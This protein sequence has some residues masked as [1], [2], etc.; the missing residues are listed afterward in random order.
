MG[1]KICFVGFAS[2][3]REWANNLPDDDWEI[4]GTNEC[5]LFLRKQPS[6]WYQIHPRG[7]EPDRSK[8]R[9]YIPNGFGRPYYHQHWLSGQSDFPIY[10]QEKDPLIPRSVRYPYEKVAALS[11]PMFLTST[12]AYMVAHAVLEQS[13]GSEIEAYTWAGIE[14]ALGTEYYVQRECF[15][16]WAGRLEGAGAERVRPPSP[17][18]SQMFAEPVYAKD[19]DRPLRPLRADEIFGKRQ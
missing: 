1:R 12:L 7:W 11:Q 6:R 9:G 10:M 18:T 13:E 2:S 5:H 14:L 16:Y 19:F 4:W 17:Y 15:A 8:E 3:S